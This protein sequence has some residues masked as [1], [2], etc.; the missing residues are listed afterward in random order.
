MP[1]GHRIWSLVQGPVCPGVARLGLLRPEPALD[2]IRP[3]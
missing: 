3:G 1:L 2:E